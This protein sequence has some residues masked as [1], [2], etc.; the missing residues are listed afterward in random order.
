MMK[1][2]DRGTKKWSAMML[3]EHQE[4]LTK[5]FHCNE[6]TM[7]P[8][9]S[10]DQVE[11]I[12]FILRRAVSDDL[13]IAIT[14]YSGNGLHSMKGKITSINAYNKTLWMNGGKITIGDIVDAE[15]L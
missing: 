1:A 5:L 8:V 2:N 9:L 13:P 4:A 10:E 14:Y 7:K 12:D 11:Q 3:T 6:H 15:I